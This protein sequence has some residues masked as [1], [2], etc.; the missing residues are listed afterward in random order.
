MKRRSKSRRKKRY[1][2]LRKSKRRRR[3]RSRKSRRRS[4]GRSKSRRRRRSQKRRSSSRRIQRRSTRRRRKSKRKAAVGVAIGASLGSA[5]ALAGLGLLARRV[6]RNRL[7]LEPK[8]LKEGVR[9]CP[10][11]K[12][13]L[14]NA[15]KG[16]IFRIRVMSRAIIPG[17]YSTKFMDDLQHHYIE[18]VS[19][20]EKKGGKPCSA[21]FGIMKF[22]DNRFLSVLAPDNI[23]LRFRKKIKKFI[24]G[25]LHAKLKQ[26][27]LTE[28]FE[29]DDNYSVHGKKIY[30]SNLTDKHIA[31]LRS[32][33]KEMDMDGKLDLP[34]FKYSLLTCS[35][36]RQNCRSFAHMFAKSPEQLLQAAFGQK[37]FFELQLEL[38]AE[39][40]WKAEAAALKAKREKEAEE[41]RKAE[42]AALKA[43]REKEAEEKRKA[44]A[45]ALKAKQ[46]K[47]AEMRSA[48]QRAMESVEDEERKFWLL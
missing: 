25:N 38:E 17:L 8:I 44:E 1:S 2:R 14:R 48:F 23:L 42:A 43:K 45:A 40:K 26:Y 37:K 33:H 28:L 19:R 11:D 3:K 16:D 31:F 12:K 21:T 22:N 13:A 18:I 4:K 15:K 34:L 7:L 35:P 10:K 24:K 29:F 5:A 46:E 32:I 20:T 27:R 6:N 47:D 41:K 36:N 30:E 9:F 39:E